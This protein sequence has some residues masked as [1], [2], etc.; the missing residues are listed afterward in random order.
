MR[1]K[2]RVKEVWKKRKF[3]LYPRFNATDVT[4]KAVGGLADREGKIHIET[5]NL[6]VILVCNVIWERCNFIRC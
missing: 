1:R 6:T 4:L 2:R 3:L 5:M